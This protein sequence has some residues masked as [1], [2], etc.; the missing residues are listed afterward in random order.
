M[1]EK[2]KETADEYRQRIGAKEKIASFI[3]KQKQPYEWKKRYAE[4][5][6]HEF[7]RECGVRDLDYHVS[8][9]GLDSITLLCFIRSL[10]YDLPAISASHLE[11]VSIRKVHKQLGVIPV[12]PIKDKEGKPYTQRRIIQEFGFP[13]ISKQ[14]AGAIARLQNPTEENAT[15]RHAYVT[16]ETGWYG[17]NKKE[18][19]M[20][21]KDRWL[22]L[23]AGGENEREGTNYKQADFKV[24]NM[25]CKY[26]KEDP[27]D[28]WAQ[29]HQS[30]PFLGLMASEG[31]QRE[32][33]LKL[34]GC[35]YFGKST[36]RSCPFAIFNRQD[37]LQLALDLEVPVPEAY[38]TIER[39]GDGT[40]YTTGAKR[41]GCA[42]CGFG[43]HMEKSP[44]RFDRKLEENPV[45]WNNLMYH[46]VTRED[47]SEYGWAHVLDYIGIPYETPT[48][49]IP[50]QMTMITI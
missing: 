16:G 26:L 46:M 21:L 41:T 48:N 1:S 24:S 40:L 7:I 45:E 11:H 49:R 5:R 25:C 33:A 32:M 13:V 34:Y 47:G 3:V 36:I 30:V 19:T 37:L 28:L 38:G 14:V 22:E 44:H 10:G 42:M 35:N 12:A 20:K 17:G 18:S 15:I 23:F 6:V 27:C 2:H 50:R 39:K 29:E 4:T 43:I 9:G 31:G 8:V